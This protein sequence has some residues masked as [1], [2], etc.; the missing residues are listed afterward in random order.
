MRPRHTNRIPGCQCGIMI[1][2]SP[3]ENALWGL[4]GS[5]AFSRLTSGNVPTRTSRVGKFTGKVH[6]EAGLLP[7]TRPPAPESPSDSGSVGAPVVGTPA[8]RPGPPPWTLAQRGHRRWQAGWAGRQKGAAAGAH[9]CC[10]QRLCHGI[11]RLCCRVP[12]HRLQRGDR[13][14][15]RRPQAVR[16][17][18]Q[19]RQ[20][21]RREQVA[22]NQA[23]GGGGSRGRAGIPGA[24][25]GA[26]VPG[27]PEGRAPWPPGASI[28]PSIQ[29]AQA[30]TRA[31]CRCTQ[32]S[33]APHSAQPCCR[34]SA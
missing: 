17:A 10:A 3:E 27:V 18:V 9:L 7:G 12:Q 13:S 28:H 33:L 32:A 22:C 8:R 14:L 19:P 1:L 20:Q 26:G 24:R 31:G 34:S 30:R 25:G 6:R 29:L 16:L 23:A 4:P 21:Q 15:E 5:Q 2:I 11:S